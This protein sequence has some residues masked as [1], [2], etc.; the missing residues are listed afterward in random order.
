MFHWAAKRPEDF[1]STDTTDEMYDITVKV[2]GEPDPLRR[3]NFR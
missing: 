2:R 1:P 3:W